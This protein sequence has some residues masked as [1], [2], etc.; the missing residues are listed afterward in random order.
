MDEE[1]WLVRHSRKSLDW[2]AVAEKVKMTYGIELIHRADELDWKDCALWKEGG[3]G[4]LRH[5][6]VRRPKTG[7]A[8]E[9]PSQLADFDLFGE[10]CQQPLLVRPSLFT[11]LISILMADTVKS[12]KVVSDPGNSAHAFENELRDLMKNKPSDW[13][14]E[15]R[16]DGF[17]TRLR[18]DG[19]LG[20]AC[21]VSQ[22]KGIW[23]LNSLRRACGLD[24]SESF[25][26]LDGSFKVAEAS[27]EEVSLRVSMIPS[28]NGL[29][30]AVRFLYAQSQYLDSLASLGMQAHQQNS[31]LEYWNKQRELFLVCG[32]TGSGK[33]TTLHVLLRMA[34]QQNKKVLSAEDPVE[35]LVP[36][37]QQVQVNGTGFANAL[38][39]FMRQ[40]PDTIMIGEIRDRITAETV[41]H[42]AY[43]GHRIL[44]TLHAGST[45]GVF[46]RFE[47]F[48]IHETNLTHI[49]GMVI[50]QRLLPVLCKQC[51]ISTF[52]D[53]ELIGMIRD[54]TGLSIKPLFHLASGCKHCH[55]GYA[56]RAAIFHLDKAARSNCTASQLEKET[57]NLLANGEIDPKTAIS[58]LNL[59]LRGCFSFHYC[60]DFAN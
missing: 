35:R 58:L 16:K 20:T 9:H 31:L 46:K 47:D 12:G 1:M 22:K 53:K 10:H 2:A 7:F 28:I 40:A 13:H 43:S 50:H 27:G 11:N 17:L 23:F 37:V 4:R 34:V 38:R 6:M 57:I 21:H 59:P 32:P 51:R 3:S 14:L 48:G 55:Q 36:G 52:P 26:P 5:F 42:S 24:G 44:A 60:K 39:A 29:S 8:M 15:P 30:V 18:C 41:L 45:T 54:V 19:V 49:L 25:K 33:S 56:G